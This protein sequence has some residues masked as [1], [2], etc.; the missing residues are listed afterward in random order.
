MSEEETEALNE[1]RA[2][3]P[4]FKPTAVTIPR[5]GVSKLACIGTS[6]EPDVG[7]KLRRP[8]A[9]DERAAPRTNDLWNAF[10]W[11]QGQ[12]QAYRRRINNMRVPEVVRDEF[13]KI[14]LLY[15]VPNTERAVTTYDRAELEVVKEYLRKINRYDLPEEMYVKNWRGVNDKDNAQE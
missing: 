15:V 14:A 5:Q 13:I 6:I 11:V 1:I 8:S 12:M 4:K 10:L 7:R 2:G 9:S 3:L